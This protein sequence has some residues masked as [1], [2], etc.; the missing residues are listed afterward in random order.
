MVL[1]EKNSSSSNERTQPLQR[2]RRRCL[3]GT[4]TL[5][6]YL[7][8]ALGGIIE[9]RPPQETV[10]AFPKFASRSPQL[11]EALDLWEAASIQEVLR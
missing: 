7:R 2:P 11:Q 8:R 1:S 3:R 10:E 9:A 5:T 4:V 6:P